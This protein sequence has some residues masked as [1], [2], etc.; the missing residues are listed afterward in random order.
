MHAREVS[1]SSG[2]AEMVKKTGMRV[3]GPSVSQV[4]GMRPRDRGGAGSRQEKKKKTDN[5]K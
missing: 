1:F 5:E 4:R 2:N 3:G